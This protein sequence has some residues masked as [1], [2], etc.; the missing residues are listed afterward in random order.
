MP[1]LAGGAYSAS[2]DPLAGSWGGR[3]KW[4]R[5][6]RRGGKWKGINRRG[7]GGER[8]E[9]GVGEREGRGTPE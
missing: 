4:R 9:G 5:K 1:G 2:L 8:N 6:G 7:K 3:G